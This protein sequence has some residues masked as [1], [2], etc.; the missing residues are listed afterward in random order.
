MEKRCLLPLLCRMPTLDLN[1]SKAALHKDA[2]SYWFL[3]TYQINDMIS[4]YEKKTPLFD[5]LAP[6][7]K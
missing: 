6:P 1:D 4:T 5:L 3:S 2:I 7:R